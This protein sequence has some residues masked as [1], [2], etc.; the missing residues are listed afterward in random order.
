MNITIHRGSHQIGGSCIELSAGNS[1]ILLDIGKAL[2]SLDE[3]TLDETA[4]LP[5]VKVLIDKKAIDAV[6]ISHSHGDHVGLIGQVKPAIPVYIGK[7]ALHIYN[8]TA[9]F[10]G[11][12]TLANP[13]FFF[14]SGQPLKIG[15]FTITPYLVD[16][17]G[18]DAYGFLIE[19]GGKAVVY[20]GDFRDHGKKAK[21]TEYFKKHLPSGID[22]LLIEGTMMSRSTEALETEDQLEDKARELMQ[23]SNQPVLVLQSS[24]N[25]D[26]LVGMYRAATRSGRLFVMDIFTAHIVSQLAPSIP[27]PSSSFDSIRVI[28]PF[29]LTRKMFEKD[30]VHLMN[31]FS[32]YKIK[33]EELSQRQDYC[34]LFRPSMLSDLQHIDQLEGAEM[35]Y[36]QWS[37]YKHQ[38]KIKAVLD[39]AD[40]KTMTL[41]DLH[42]SGHASTQALKAFIQQCNPRM[43]LPIH[44]ENPDGF[45]E[46]GNRVYLPQDGERIRL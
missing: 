42:T 46:C 27:K 10:T 14:E 3:T 29:W 9:L 25:I 24:T 23:S 41:T 16:H 28:Y 17:S 11:G 36:S 44:T 4:L 40:Q 5:G 43:V 34:L 7:A 30:H 2:P 8:T 33:R 32:R 15:D 13:T 26:R 39:F 22:A 18:Y 21:A 35:I 38:K 45:L 31:Q 6:L 20:T 12:K 37:G 1:R 19:A